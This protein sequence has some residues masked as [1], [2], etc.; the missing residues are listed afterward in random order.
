MP[1]VGLVLAGGFAKG[2]YQ[3]GILKA[4]NEF[5]RCNEIECISA[6]SIG[7]INAYAFVQNQLDI[8]EN[9]WTSVDIKSFRSFA[10]HYFKGT[11]IT[12]VIN[13]LVSVKAFAEKNLYIT[14]FNCS[15][16]VLEY[17]NLN[18]TKKDDIRDFL[19]AG[20][21]MPVFNG[22]VTVG[23]MKYV[24]GGLVDNIPVKPL[25]KHNLDYSIVIHFDNQNY[26]FENNTFDKKLI[27]INFLD[28][29]RIKNSFAFDKQSISYMIN[30]GYNESI[31]L[32]T[33]I[34]KNG[35]DDLEYIYDRIRYNNN[36]NGNKNRR[37]T[38][39]VVV[40]NINKILKKIISSNI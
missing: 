27:K 20:V 14:C 31:T 32:L 16:I 3:I 22:A 38:G 11:Y 1:K 29:K 17:I 18:K 26:I 30:T 2:A 6:S 24:D 36:L 37:F 15:K 19:C 28:E 4:L 40:G 23:G 5:F 9:M 21:A 13:D 10:N 12:N 35:L 39:D 7:S 8:A 34:F 25:I 33:S